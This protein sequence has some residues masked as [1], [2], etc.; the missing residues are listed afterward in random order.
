MINHNSFAKAFALL[1]LLSLFFVSGFVV[2]PVSAAT[3]TVNSTADNETNDNFCTLR[4][5]IVAANTD[6]AYRGCPTGSGEDTILLP[7]G[8]VTIQSQLPEITSKIIINGYSTTSTIIQASECNPI[9]QPEGCLPANYRIFQVNSGSS[10]SVNKMTIRHGK[11]T[12]IGGAIKNFGTL[13]VVDSHLSGNKANAGGAISNQKGL[14]VINRSI[15]SD[16]YALESGGISNNEGTVL[17]EK[18]TLERN[19]SDYR[20]GGIFNYAGTVGIINATIHFNYAGLEGG[21][22]YNI[23]GGTVNILN[24][25]IS[26][27][28]SWKDGGGIYN[29]GELMVTN[30]TLSDNN[31]SGFGGGFYSTGGSVHLE[32]TTISENF[33]V[34]SGSGAYITDSI[35]N[36]SN[37]IIANSFNEDCFVNW[38]NG[39]RIGTN[40]HNLVEDN[41]CSVGGINFLSG[42]PKLGLLADNGG[43]TKTHALLANSPAI[44]RGDCDF[45]QETDQR[46]EMR[47]MGLA[48]D[49]G[50]YERAED[51]SIFLPL[52]LR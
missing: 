29:N 10:L 14:T 7:K 11:E 36:F 17:I 47:P 24:S 21:G 22:V 42:D 48:C 20:S 5:A 8:T 2:T 33:S 19:T 1:V 6:A 26:K 3:I 18:S 15:I 34:D 49:I 31:A 9:T 28:T 4:E 37:N 50:A 30:S 51:K 46:G 52:I 41:S 40:T 13:F 39:G 32:S 27:N 38:D 25:T 16:N 43:P 45:S 12:N 44:D 23:A 35:L